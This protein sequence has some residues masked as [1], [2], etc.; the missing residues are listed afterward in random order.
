MPI[1]RPL[2]PGAGWIEVSLYRAYADSAYEHL[3]AGRYFD[4]IVV[5]CVGYDVLVNTLPDRIRLHHHEELTPDQ[6][7]VIDDIEASE[8]LTAGKLLRKLAK[9]NILHW[10]LDRALRRFNEE[11]N[12]VIHPIERKEEIDPNGNTS[13]ILSL[14]EAAVFPYKATKEDA[15]RYL[16][17]FCHI[18]DLSGGE[19]PRK[20]ERAMRRYSLS[21]I[22]EE[23]E[24][25]RRV[26]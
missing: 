13:F 18:I 8:R 25:E 3:I 4:A 6:R 17:W 2:S 12:N 5:S 1:L 23:I 11:R 16:R 7:K 21:S 15:D 9:A 14:K 19:S 26:E 10:R 24:D 20:Q 22:L